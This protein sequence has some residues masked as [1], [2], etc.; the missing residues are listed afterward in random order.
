[1]QERS[2]RGGEEEETGVHDSGGELFIGVRDEEGGGGE[3]ATGFDTAGFGI[4]TAGGQPSVISGL[5]LRP[6]NSKLTQHWESA[7]LTSFS[8]QGS[9]PSELKAREKRERKRHRAHKKEIARRK[10]RKE[11]RHLIRGM[12]NLRIAQ[13]VAAGGDP[14][15][16][17]EEDEDEENE[18]WLEHFGGGRIEEEDDENDDEDF[19]GGAGGEGASQPVLAGH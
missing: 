4:G 7:R 13:R 5:V 10:R 19:A 2:E 17:K 3:E 14:D 8:R 12:R 6:K 9:S 16:E 1:M 15:V 18:I 11:N